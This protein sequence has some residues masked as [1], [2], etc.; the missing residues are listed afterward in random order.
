M[1]LSGHSELGDAPHYCQLLLP[2]HADTNT[3]INT[4]TLTL[5]RL[6]G[7]CITQYVH[8][9]QR[10]LRL[11]HLVA[12]FT[13]ISASVARTQFQRDLVTFPACPIMPLSMLSVSFP[14]PPHLDLQLPQDWIRTAVLG[15][16]EVL[17]NTPSTSTMHL[18]SSS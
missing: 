18:S 9:M 12:C 3:H 16:Q 1:S 8:Y 14:M 13:H 2:L 7:L 17:A 6:S 11:S 10:N 5:S 4:H 15:E